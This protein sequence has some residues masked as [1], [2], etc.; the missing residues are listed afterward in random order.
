M[1][2]FFG[3]SAV[4]EAHA[5]DL[6][7]FSVAYL[8]P[9]AFVFVRRAEG[10]PV[11]DRILRSIDACPKCRGRAGGD[12]PQSLVLSSGTEG[13]PDVLVRLT[14]TRGE[15]GAWQCTYDGHVKRKL[16]LLGD[17]SASKTDLVR[18]LVHDEVADSARD[19]LGAKVMTRHQTVTVPDESADLHVVFTVWDIAGHRFS[20]KRRMRAFFHGARAVLAVCDLAREGTVQELGY[21]LAVAER[22]LGKVSMVIVAKGRDAP[23]PLAIAE[24]R[25]RDLAREH[26]AVLVFVPP[27][28]T[29][30][31]EHVFEAFGDETI[32]DVFGTSW[33][34]RM[35]A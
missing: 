27:R 13:G 2:G 3:A 6:A 12:G 31:A 25:V 23:D 14:C 11:L 22:V 17:A 21:W 24:A 1:E 9:A 19:L 26:H 5:A 8:Q 33:G 4:C 29:H 35:Y 7:Q 30:A 15:D 32:R 34:P 28:D 20:D 18:P 10:A 16:L